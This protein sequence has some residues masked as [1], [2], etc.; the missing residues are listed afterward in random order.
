MS[1]RKKNLPRHDF[2]F[3]D[4]VEDIGFSGSPCSS[5]YF[6]MKSRIGLPIN[7]LNKKME[8]TGSPV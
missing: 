1:K 2:V 3:V 8:E 6:L 7:S 5:R 4:E